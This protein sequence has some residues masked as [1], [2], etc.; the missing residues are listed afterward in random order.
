MAKSLAEWIEQDV[1]PMQE[2]PVSYLSQYHFFRDPFRPAYSDS[3]VFFP[4]ADG[5]ILYQTIVQPEDPLLDIKGKRYSLQD[6]LQDVNFDHTCLVIGIF[7]TMYDV[8]VNRI[9]YE[10]RLSYRALD[11]IDTYNHPMLDVE[12]ELLADL[13]FRPRSA[14]YLHYNER[15]ANRVFSPELRLYYYILQIADYDVDCITP[16][17]I[18]QNQPVAQG[19]RFSMIRY[20]S[21]VDLI[22]PLSSCHDFQ[23]LQPTHSHVEAGV[24][25]LIRVVERHTPRVFQKGDHHA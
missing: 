10:G 18:K 23:L 6:A 4:P 5:V 20:G 7:M 2:R 22:V 19:D 8:H 9:P 12:K 1:R 3:S 15:V 11:A 14:D 17:H 24:D 21:Q 13:R 16:F 25:P